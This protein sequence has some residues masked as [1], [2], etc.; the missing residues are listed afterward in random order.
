MKKLIFIL[1]PLVLCCS[2]TS[3]VKEIPSLANPEKITT[4]I[5]VADTIIYDVI[6]RNPNPDD[7]WTASC[8]K[9]LQRSELVD[10]LF[11]WV[12]NGKL[13]AYDF[14]S[15]QKLNVNDIE[16]IESAKDFDREKIG[17]IQFMEKW[18]YDGSVPGLNK[19]IISLVLGYEVYNESGE[20]RG[21]K[22][23]FK[24]RFQ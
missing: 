3:P 14:D 4:Q 2:K 10:S 9:G 7:T 8:L 16:K 6:I 12:Y 5:L 23:V 21:Y 15:H 22:P 24:M 18:Y 11:A 13:S 20:L 19:E 17:K 1:L